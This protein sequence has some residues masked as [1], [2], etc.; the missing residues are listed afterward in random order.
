MLKRL[1]Y[2]SVLLE[3]SREKGIANM[4]FIGIFALKVY[5]ALL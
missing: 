1:L 5:I 4:R 2:S 3:A